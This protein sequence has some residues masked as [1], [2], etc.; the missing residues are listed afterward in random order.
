MNDFFEIDFVKAG[1]KNSGD[2]IALRYSKDVESRMYIHVVDG[3][4]TNDGQ[5]LVDHI[6]KAYGGLPPQKRTRS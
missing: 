4:Y 2:A 3:G 5:K 1:E 6:K